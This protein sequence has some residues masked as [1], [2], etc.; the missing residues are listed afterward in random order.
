MPITPKTTALLSI[1]LVVL[2]WGSASS[3]TKLAVE[4]IPP[5][6][7]AFLRNL[8]ASLCLLI[9]FI[10]RRKKYPHLP[11]AMPWKNVIWM[12]LTGI[13]FFYVSFNLGLYYTTAAAGALIQGFIPVAIILLAT[14]FLKEKVNNIQVTG[15]VLSVAGV[16]M[17]GFI[18]G[19]SEARNEMLGN[20]LVILSVICWAVYTIISKN[21]Q[22]YDPIYLAAYATWIGTAFLI[23]AVIIEYYNNPFIPSLSTNGWMAILYLG[24]LSSAVCYVLYNQV[25]KIL[26]AVQVGSFMNLD[27]VVGAII[28]VVLLG[29]RITAWQIGGAML[30][31]VGVWLT[32]GKNSS[33]QN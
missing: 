20:I 21:M 10:Y 24:V 15:V 13:S 5:Y 31:L 3:V 18:G 30:V 26:S 19:S 2:I 17:I 7:F 32:S 25:M 11:V 4:D 1:L 33:S 8:T 27:P 12:G 28:A 16:I 23:P 6:I 14:M 22:A 9:I 29:E